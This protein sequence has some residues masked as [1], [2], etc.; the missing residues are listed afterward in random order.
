MSSSYGHLQ[1]SIWV[2]SEPV[3]C[4]RSHG[5][6]R[7]EYWSWGSQWLDRSDIASKLTPCVTLT[8][9]AVQRLR[10]AYQS[11]DIG[12]FEFTIMH[13]VRWPPHC[14]KWNNQHRRWLPTFAD[15]LIESAP[16]YFSRSMWTSFVLP[17]SRG[18]VEFVCLHFRNRIVLNV[19]RPGLIFWYGNVLRYCFKPWFRLAAWRL[20]MSPKSYRSA[21][22]KWR[23]LL[24]NCDWLRTTVA[25]CWML[26]LG[27]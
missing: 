9:K 21:H 4:T 16:M 2:R 20:N 11:D 7:P 22:L 25:C 1:Y 14:S 15:R 18:W 23:H 17:F 27:A 24:S 3:W 12:H 10:V 8:V 13:P 19:L 26:L 5:L 6:R